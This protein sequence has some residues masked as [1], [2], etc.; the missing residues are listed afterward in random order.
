MKRILVYYKLTLIT[1][2]S[3]VIL[4]ICGLIAIINNFTQQENINLFIFPISLPIVSALVFI[5]LDVLL[6]SNSI[7]EKIYKD[8]YPLTLKRTRRLNKLKHVL[9]DL[10]FIFSLIIIV[11]SMFMIFVMFSKFAT[12][13]SALY[14][15]LLILGFCHACMLNRRI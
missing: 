13:G 11:V 15:V 10:L 9:S 14:I 1:S 2:V 4:T 12:V 5:I 7:N 3:I 6:I 8:E